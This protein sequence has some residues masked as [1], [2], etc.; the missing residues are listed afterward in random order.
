MSP[1]PSRGM[2]KE[3]G[4]NQNWLPHPCLLVGQKRERITMSPLH[5]RG[6]PRKGDKIRIGCLTPAFSGAQKSA[7]SVRH[8]CIL[9]EP[10]T[11]RD[12]IRIGCLTL[13]FSGAQK[14][15]EMRCHPCIL[16]DP[17]TKRD[18]IRIGCLKSAF[19]GVQKRAEMLCHPCILGDPQTK[20][21][22]IRIGCLIPAYTKQLR[23]MLLNIHSYRV[24]CNF[25]RQMCVAEKSLSVVIF[26]CGKSCKPVTRGKKSRH[27]TFFCTPMFR[28]KITPPDNFFVTRI[29]RK[30]HTQLTSCKKIT[31]CHHMFLHA[32]AAKKIYTTLRQTKNYQFYR[33]RRPVGRVSTGGPLLILSPRLALRSPENAWVTHHFRPLLG[34]REGTGEAAT[35]DFIPLCLGIPEKARVKQPLLILSPFVWGS[36]RMQ[37]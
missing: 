24:C 7:E 3:R 28:K 33:K 20:G 30:Q 14:R 18:K 23:A 26:F 37:G 36:P 11:K 12:K 34:P 1:L 9:G 21:D 6:S 16:R 25:L 31:P 5:S 35:F 32:F 8:P 22:K 10:K 4:Q 13:A 15:A 19:L 29:H 17:Q 27:L 2:P